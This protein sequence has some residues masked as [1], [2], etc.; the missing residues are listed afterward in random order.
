MAADARRCLL[1]LED[2]TVFRGFG[3]AAHGTR[4]GEVV[5]NTSM[6]GYGEI[7]TDP[8]YCGQIVVMTSPHIGNYGITLRDHESAKPWLAGLVVR[9]LAARHSNHRA[10]VALGQFLDDHQIVALQGVDTRAL[11]KLVRTRG[12]LRGLITTEIDDPA[13]CVELARQSPTMQGADLVATVAPTDSFEWTE[14][15]DCDFNTARSDVTTHRI[16][17]IDC[18]MKRNILRHLVDRAGPVHVVPPT[19]S[20]AEILD[21]CPDGVLVSNGPGDPAAAGRT[22]ETLRQLIGQVPIFGICLGHQLLALALGGASYKLKFGHH[23]GNQPVRNLATGRIEITAQ[24][25]GFAIDSDSLKPSGT[26]MTHVNLNDQTLEGFSHPDKALFAVQYHPEAGPG[27]HDA[28]YLFDCF[29][30][31]MTSGRPP[32]AEDL[33][34]AQSICHS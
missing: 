29:I 16:V 18:G 33:A 17:A 28:T 12:A 8:S 24:N 19:V 26:V 4:S 21:Q 27:P 13:E 3:F 25:H 14:G 10:D 34:D 7:L 30:R 5:F 32:N 6:S 20:A 1:A 31:M 9:E 22:I 23:G 2:G 15:L 11:T